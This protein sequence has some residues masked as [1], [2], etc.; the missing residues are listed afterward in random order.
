MYVRTYIRTSYTTMYMHT[1]IRSSKELYVHIS[2]Y[3]CLYECMYVHS[4]TFTQDSCGQQSQHIGA[5][6]NIIIFTQNIC[7]TNH[8][9][10]LQPN[11]Q[12]Q[13]TKHLPTSPKSYAYVQ[14]M[15]NEAPIHPQCDSEDTVTHKLLWSR[16]ASVR[17][18]CSEC[19]HPRRQ[20]LTQTELQNGT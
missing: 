16:E 18:V 5:P 4:K 2:T 17:Q 1:Q 9:H 14:C 7:K 8:Y 20:C 11:P 15:Y 3:V 13:W 10:H 6:A 12:S 19:L